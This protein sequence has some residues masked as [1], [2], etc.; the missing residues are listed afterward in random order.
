M[1]GLFYLPDKSFPSV[2]KYPRIV[3]WTFRNIQESSP[4]VLRISRNHRPLPPLV[5]EVRNITGRSSRIIRATP[6]M[7]RWTSTV[8]EEVRPN[9][10][11]SP[12]E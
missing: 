10:G 5:V 6:R 1:R 12:V 4:F 9:H 3:G 11:G 8:H 2:R 7:Y